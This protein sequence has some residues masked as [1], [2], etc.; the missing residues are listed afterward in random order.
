[1]IYLDYSA[2]TPTDKDVLD[3]FYKSSLEYIGNPNSSHKLGKMGY[4]KISLATNNIIN[5][6]NLDD[7]FDLI[8]TS[9][10]SEAN[11]LAIKGLAEKSKTKHI[12]TTLLEHSSV[13]GPISYLQK[14]GYEIDFLKLDDNGQI[15]LDYLKSILKEDTF[16]V[17]ISSVNSEVG[18]KEKLKEISEIVKKFP[19]CKLH[20]DV[21]QSIGKHQIDLNYVDMASFSAQ[22]FYG[23]KGIG[24]LIKKKDIKLEPMIH[25]GKSTTIYRSGTPALPLILSL[26]KALEKTLSKIDEN[27]NYV[28]NI[29]KELKEFLNKYDKVHINSNDRC[30]PHILN[31]SIKDLNSKQI[32]EHFDKND[33]YISTQT[34][35]SIDDTP[36]RIVMALTKSHDLA[37]SSFR[38]SLSHLTTK[39]EIEVLK[40]KVDE[41]LK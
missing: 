38:I 29:N 20:V 18:I 17:S 30:I 9:G 19:N 36:S 5:M 39:E 37:R 15:D 21:T 7:S 24:G 41:L 34:A 35:C 4:E 28:L 6:L 40:E 27:F 23:I 11:N 16:L 33:I 13:I 32:L 1:M 10:A 3:I 12:I 8:Y 14:E 31:V 2:T 22:K 25:G 26:E